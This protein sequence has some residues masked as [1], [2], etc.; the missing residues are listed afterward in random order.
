MRVSFLTKL[1]VCLGLLFTDSLAANDDNLEN[2]VKVGYL[3]NFTKFVAWPKINSATFNLCILGNDPF[4]TVIDPIEKKTALSRSIRVVRLNSTNSLANIIGK[5]E[6]HILYV[7]G[8]ISSKK[9]VN[10]IQAQLNKTNTL[11]VGESEA[12]AP[13]GGMIG[14]INRNGKI[15]LQINLQSV[16]RTD[17]RISAKLLEI[18]ELIKGGKP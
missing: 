3:Y 10:N 18:A 9:V 2:K 5:Q 4:G 6:C 13:N 1:L 14:F 17:L 8:F 12:F 16:N 7:S 15:R 11:V